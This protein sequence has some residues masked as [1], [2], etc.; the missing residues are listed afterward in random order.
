MKRKIIGKILL[1]V[2]SA[3]MLLLLN[4]VLF[5]MILSRSLDLRVIYVASHDIP[6][7]TE[8][9]EEDI[10]EMTVSGSYLPENTFTEKEQILGKYTEIRGMIPAGSPFYYPMLHDR[11]QLPDGPLTMLRE[12]ESAYTMETDI[13]KLGSISEGMHVDIH[14]SADHPESVPSAGCLITHARVLSV[15]DHQGRKMDDPEGSGIPYLIEIAV[16]REDLD[17]LSV[18]ESEGS[19]RVFSSADPYDDAAEAQ[20]SSSEAVTYLL[21][22][23]GPDA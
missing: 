2:L 20:R 21:E 3:G 1:C 5:T 22:R 12:G 8:I 17:L 18:A 14:F 11:A 10:A 6:P 7:R 15:K 13:T 16:R 9:K 19:L 4:Y 23:M